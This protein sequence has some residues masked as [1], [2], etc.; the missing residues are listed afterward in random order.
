MRIWNGYP[1]YLA[2]CTRFAYGGVVLEVHLDGCKSDG[3]FLNDFQKAFFRVRWLLVCAPRR[4]GG[5]VSWL[6]AMCEINVYIKYMSHL[7]FSHAK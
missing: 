6:S 7:A 2:R 4:V 1:L 3:K 5:G